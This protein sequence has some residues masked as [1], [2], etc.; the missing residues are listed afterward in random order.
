MFLIGYVSW[1]LCVTGKYSHVSG[2]ILDH[3]HR[4]PAPQRI[5]FKLCLTMYKV[6]NGLEP[7]Y[8]A[9]LCDSVNVGRLLM[10]TL[11]FRRPER[12]LVTGHRGMARPSWPGWLV[13]YWDRFTGT[14]DWTPD[15]VTHL[16]TNRARWR[17]VTV[18]HLTSA[19][20]YQ[21]TVSHLHWRHSCLQFSANR[22]LL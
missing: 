7:E 3:L 4:L 14:G 9:E 5:R 20:L 1:M 8:L 16:S 6:V 11:Q 22:W 18:C 12:S 15:T 17:L 19:T 2:L 21:W 10:E 13:I